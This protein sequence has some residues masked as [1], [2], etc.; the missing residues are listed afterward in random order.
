MKKFFLDLGEASGKE[1]EN[2]T[3]Q[4]GRKNTVLILT[5]LT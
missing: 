4:S 2:A 3:V 1:Q 5:I